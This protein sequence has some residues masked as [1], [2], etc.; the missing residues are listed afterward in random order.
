[1]THTRR[2][3]RPLL[4]RITDR[5][6]AFVEI[7][8]ARAEQDPALAKHMLATLTDLEKAIPNLS[9]DDVP[10]PAYRP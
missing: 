6:T 2:F 10:Q 7:L 8:A 3:T 4:T 5:G 1:M 9:A